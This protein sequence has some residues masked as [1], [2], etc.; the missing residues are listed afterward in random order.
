VS[1]VCMAAECHSGTLSRPGAAREPSA[2]IA[3]GGV[4]HSNVVMEV[5]G[6]RKASRVGDWTSRAW[7]MRR[8]A[9]L[10]RTATFRY[11]D[12]SGVRQKRLPLQL[13]HPGSPC[14]QYSEDEHHELITPK[15][16]HSYQTST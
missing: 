9:E 10:P 4:P 3:V 8:F 1:T 2:V 11:T 16:T 12:E 14:V 13:K 6:V 7:S 15:P 5:L